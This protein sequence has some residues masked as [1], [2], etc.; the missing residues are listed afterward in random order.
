MAYIEATCSLLKKDGQLIGVSLVAEPQT[1]AEIFCASFPKKLSDEKDQAQIGIRNDTQLTFIHPKEGE[2]SFA[3][4]DD[5]IEAVRQLITGKSG[6]LGLYRDG[7]MTPGF[8]I[9][10]QDDEKNVER[11]PLQRV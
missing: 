9:A 1:E 5:D 8:K 3:L 4:P 6:N 2:V 11:E 10:L 7:F